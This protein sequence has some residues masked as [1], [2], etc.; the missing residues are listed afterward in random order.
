MNVR[1]GDPRQTRD[2]PCGCGGPHGAHAHAALLELERKHLEHLRELR[3][4]LAAENDGLG[5]SAA[6][7][8]AELELVNKSILSSEERLTHATRSH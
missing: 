8:R 4:Q 3:R 1:L 7:L 6:E 2:T 5:P